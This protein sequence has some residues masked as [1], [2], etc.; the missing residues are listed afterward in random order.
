MTVYQQ[1]RDPMTG[2][3]SDAVQRMSDGA[4]IPADPRNS[5]WQAYQAWLADGNAPDPPPAPVASQAAPA[6]AD[7]LLQ[8][9]ALTER[10]E[11]CEARLT[12]LEGSS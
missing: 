5:D 10:I 11:A 8:L 7:P 4:T 3:I 12:L 9:A 2:A 1:C 6:E